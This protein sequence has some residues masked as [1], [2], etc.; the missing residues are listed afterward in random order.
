MWK[1]GPKNASTA[2][3]ALF[4]NLRYTFD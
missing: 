3:S 2:F 1:K 4:V